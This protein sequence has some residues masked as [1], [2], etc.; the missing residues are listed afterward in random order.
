VQADVAG[1]VADALVNSVRVGFEEE[2]A[3]SSIEAGISSFETGATAGLASVGFQVLNFT[4]F[5]TPGPRAVP[6]FGF[7]PRVTDLQAGGWR[8]RLTA[9]DRSKD[10]FKSLDEIGGWPLP[11]VCHS[12][13]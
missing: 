8:V 12:R 9:V 2:M 11:P 7:P 1:G 6:V 3:F 13:S 5:L 10:I 4:D